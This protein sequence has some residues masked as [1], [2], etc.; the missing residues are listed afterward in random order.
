M[1]LS[2]KN[3]GDIQKISS[4]LYLLNSLISQQQVQWKLWKLMTLSFEYENV[5]ATD[6]CRA[7]YCLV[8]MDPCALIKKNHV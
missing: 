4:E 1:W 3:L 2:F 8:C 7:Q 6:S 5:Q